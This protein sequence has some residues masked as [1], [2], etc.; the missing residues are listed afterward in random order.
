MQWLW[1]I[2]TLVTMALLVGLCHRPLGDY[3]AWVFSSDKD[4][5]I[6]RV[7]YRLAGVNPKREQTWRAYLRALLVFSAVGL[8]LLYLLQRCQPWLPLSGG[9]GAVPP[10]QAFNTAVS[11]VTN[12]NWQSSAPDQSL[13]YT[14][15]MAGLTVQNFVSA[16]VGLAVAIALIR[17]LTRRRATTIGNFWVD[18]TRACL[19][20]L[21]P[22]ALIAAIILL[23]GGVIQNLHGGV[24][25]TT[26]AGGPQTLPG[27]PV[28]SQEAIKLLGTNGGGFFAANSAHPYENP[29]G[30][31][32]LFEAFLLLVI[33]FALPRTFA[34]MAKDAR[35]GRTI[36]ATMATLFTLV[37]AAISY[38]ELGAHSSAAGVAGASMEGKED[39]FG[40]IGS[41]L[42]ATATTGTSGGA[43]DSAHESYTALSGLFMMIHMLAGE[44]SPGGVGAGLYTI[45][46]MAVI[47]VFLTGL[48]L[49]RAPIFVGKRIGVPQ[50]KL[51][52][53]TI[54]VLPVLVLVGLAVSFAIPG[55]KAE[56]VGQAMGAPGAQGLSESLYAFISCAVNNGSAFAGF[57]ANTPFLNT[58]L[59]VIMLFGRFLVI[60]L[61][62][63][64]AGSFA[65]Q[66][67]VPIALTELPL[68]H[69]QFIA[70]LVA[71]IIFIAVP[72]FGPVLALG[73]VAVGL[74]Q[75]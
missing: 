52:G 26:V 62:L 31:T 49:G 35:I 56:L 27:G 12:T 64:L 30:W 46:I 7:I 71:L 15:A 34:T 36:T 38:F 68:H 13:G 66:D 18:L 3:I 23:A 6:E 48:L 40:L 24:D 17:G 33:P 32:N 20:L 44:L 22:G 60:A 21:A 10:D 45:V 67:H 75:P 55:V 61:V 43:T 73:P 29:A 51:A 16:G 11:F 25:I 74:G 53:L 70:L 69:A 59:G 42:F 65:S 4:W 57:Q 8:I 5:L 2:V 41:I 63:A 54:L 72:T 47:A 39:R 37:Y 50:V 58:I 28:A 9:A 1:A 14:V 19:R